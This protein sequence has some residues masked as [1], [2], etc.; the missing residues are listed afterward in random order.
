MRPQ[1]RGSAVRLGP[2]AEFDLIRSLFADAPEALDG[3]SVGPGD[4]AA[5]LNIEDSVVLSVD[6][7]IEGV[8]FRRQWLTL[9]EIGYRAAAAALSDL[10]A[11]AA[12]PVGVLVSLALPEAEA[13]QLG[14]ALQQ[15]IREA[16]ALCECAVLGGDVTRSPGPLV[17]DVMVVGSVAKPVT[18]SAA[19]SGDEIWVTGVLGGAAGAVAAWEAGDDPDPTLR[20]AYAHP[21]P[22]VTEARW[23]ANEAGV[24]AM[25]DL[26]DGL[27]GDAAHMAAASDVGIVIEEALVP[28]HGALSR[29]HAMTVALVGG[30]DYELCVSAPKGRL[31]PLARAFE[32]HF[33]LP[34]TRVGSV[35]N[36]DGLSILRPGA[37]LPEPMDGSGFDHFKTL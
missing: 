6:L 18:R 12:R 15:G 30:E 24:H 1:A 25:I 23:L 7:T 10:A 20:S 17:L 31:G 3:V 8:H 19:R 29:E 11:M 27:M 21:V 14:P 4:D 35:T 26:S 33:G 13:A 36:G 5:V 22:R 34:L 2:G 9:P 16:C 37:T 28:A 32:D